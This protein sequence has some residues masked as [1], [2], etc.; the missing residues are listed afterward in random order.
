M[1]SNNLDNLVQSEVLKSEA[2]DQ[3]EFNGLLE[4]G[5]KRL[6][7]ARKK[8][9]APESR[10]DLAYNSAHAFSLAALRWHGYRPDQKRFYTPSYIEVGNMSAGYPPDAFRV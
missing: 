1:N 3:K 6:A 4:S 8:D 10:F 9:L 7:D 5:R 2:P